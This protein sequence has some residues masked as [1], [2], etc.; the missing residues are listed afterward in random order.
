MEREKFNI[1]AIVVGA[2]PA[3]ISAALTLKRGGKNV[4]VLERSDKAG[5][6]N[7]FGGAVYLNSIKSILPNSFNTAPYERFIVNHTYSFLNDSGSVDIKSTALA[8][9]TTATVMRPKFDAWM[10]EEAKKE[11]V[12]F[13]PKTLVKKLIYKN[14]SVIGVKTEQEKYFAPVVIL[15][16]G[17]N[18]LLS[19][20]VGLRKEFFPKDMVLSVKETYKLD[21]KILEERFN[22]E[23]ET[24]EGAMYEFF[25]GLSGFYLTEKKKK[26]PV[27]PFAIGFL[28]T[29][30]DTI[31]LGLGISLEDLVQYK[32]KPYEVLEKFKSH[33][34]VKKLIAGA[35]SN[36]YSAHMIPEYGYNH[37]SKLYANGVLIAGDAAGLINSAHFEGTNF[38]IESGKLAGETAIIA[39]NLGKYRHNILK[40]YEEKLRKS[41]VLK[42]MKS[43]RNV[44]ETLYGRKN[45]ILKYYPDKMG[46]FFETLHVVDNVDKKRKFRRFFRTIFFDRSIMD[47]FRDFRAFIKLFFEIMF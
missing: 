38:A 39:L 32:V 11:G 19:K 30:K 24:N 10:V 31:S 22:L 20:D 29:F 46:E 41:F 44:V 9:N 42:D 13:A 27:T 15:A 35:E 33:P 17:V 4:V 5:T 8:D 37:L 34:V 36:E 7:M 6:K 16:D 43:Y 25:G 26:Y 21:K 12:Y 3:G 1:D 2:G 45:S 40:V 18:S 14:G 47:L 23:P 28:Y